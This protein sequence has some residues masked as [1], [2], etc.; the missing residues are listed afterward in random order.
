ME[1]QGHA[2]EP[3]I[4]KSIYPGNVKDKAYDN[5]KDDAAATETLTLPDIQAQ[6]LRKYLSIRGKKHAGAPAYTQK[7]FCQYSIFQACEI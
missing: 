1:Q 5:I 3:K 7:S 4:L 6:I 2:L